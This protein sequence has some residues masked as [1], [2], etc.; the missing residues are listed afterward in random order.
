MHIRSSQKAQ[1]N[2][3]WAARALDLVLSLLSQPTWPTLASIMAAIASEL[4]A[5][6]DQ[7]IFKQTM[8][9]RFI[10][11]KC[12]ATHCQ[13]AAPALTAHICA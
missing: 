2:Y 5:D 6:Q 12:Y 9:I 1:V 3:C 8:T 4:A 7:S 13:S 10:G 11:M